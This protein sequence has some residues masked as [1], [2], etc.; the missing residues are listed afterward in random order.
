MD[1]IDIS[2][3][4]ALSPLAVPASRCGRSAWKPFAC[5]GSEN[6]ISPGV[7]RCFGITL[8]L[9]LCMQSLSRVYDGID[10]VRSSPVLSD[11][12]LPC[13]VVFVKGSK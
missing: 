1:A 7:R 13:I 12:V 2:L 10:I 9:M 6:S 5:N 8:P 11:I 3:E 4:V